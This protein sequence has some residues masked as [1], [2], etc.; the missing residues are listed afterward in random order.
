[1]DSDYQLDISEVRRHLNETQ[2]VGFF[3]QFLRLT[4]LLDTRATAQDGPMAVVTP[5]VQSVEERVKSLRRLRPRFPRPESMT[6]IPWP[7]FVGS[8]ERLGVLTMIEERMVAL[9]GERMR[10]RCREAFAELAR[11]EQ[12]QIRDAITGEGYETLWAKEQGMGQR[13]Q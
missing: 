8:L 6:L 1:V 13:G 9:G 5:M 2:V 7:K 10:E 3:F 4:L 12:K 11:A